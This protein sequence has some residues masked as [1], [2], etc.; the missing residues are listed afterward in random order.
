MEKEKKIRYAQIKETISDMIDL[1]AAG[2]ITADL[3][4]KILKNLLLK[5]KSNY[6]LPF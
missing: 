3:L 6:S 1:Y 5:L 2:E 4:D